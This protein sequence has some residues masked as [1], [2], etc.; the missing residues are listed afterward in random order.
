MADLTDIPQKP[1]PD[2]SSRIIAGAMSGT[3]A[4]GVDVAL[5]KID[6][7]GLAMRCRLLLHHA[8]RYESPL[9]QRIFALRENQHLTFAELAEVGREITLAHARAI[10]TALA[11]AAIAPGRLS[12]IAAHGQTMYHAPPNT[13]Q[14]LDPALLAAETACTVVSEFRRADCAAGGQGAPLVPFADRLLFGHPQRHRVLLNLGGIANITS[15]PAALGDNPPPQLIAFDTGPA[16]CVL[17]HLMRQAHHAEG[18]DRDGSLS[19]KGQADIHSVQSM[20]SDPYFLSPPPKSTDGPRMIDLFES[21]IAKSG[22]GMSLPDLLAT[23]CLF[24]A[25]AIARGLSFLVGQPDEML[26]SGGGIYNARLMHEI[27]VATGIL[28]QSLDAFGIPNQAK[29]A[30]AFA[31]LGAATLDGFPSNIPSATG[32][33]HPVILGSITPAPLSYR[34]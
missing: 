18:Y 20:L 31:L 15:L 2:D 13:I 28:P 6:G 3:S 17:D 7:R 21:T 25:G 16:N 8:Q 26:V 23:A 24:S 5:V 4:D 27:A 32:A 12:A 30:V 11:E 19:M 29:E 1:Q 10:K 9:R 34:V 14:W 22:R 33:R